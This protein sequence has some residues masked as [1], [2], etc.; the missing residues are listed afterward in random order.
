MFC[1]ILSF[2]IVGSVNNVDNNL[3]FYIYGS[4]DTGTLVGGYSRVPVIV[5]TTLT[6]SKANQEVDRTGAM[7]CLAG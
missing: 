7:A 1:V 6:R 3:N 5:R 2:G 4:R